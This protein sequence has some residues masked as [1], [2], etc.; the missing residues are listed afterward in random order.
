MRNGIQFVQTELLDVAYEEDGPRSGAPVILLHGWPDDVR[1]WDG[2]AARLSAAG[3][4]TVAPYLRGC[5]PGRF[6]NESTIR[7]GQLAALGSD[8]VEMAR[9]LGLGRFALVGHDWGARAAYIAT[10]ELVQHVTHLV[11][12]S[13]GYGT[14]DPRQQLQ[15]VQVR[16]YW[17]HWYFALPQGIDLVKNSRRELAR[18]L[19]AT[20]SPAW[21]FADADYAATAAS[22]DNPDWAEVTVHSYRHRWG[23]ADGDPRYDALER[24]LSCVPAIQVPTLVLHGDAD[25]CNDPVTSADKGKFFTSRYE[26]K[27]LPGIG[28]FP[29]R[30]TPDRVAD[31]VIAWLRD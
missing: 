5:G 15:L 25:A 10:T 2:V 4:H 27:L 9:A 28:H 16:N 7:S 24:R 6:L 31:E 1:T 22:F 30:E 14:N 11:T 8:V 13:V 23:Y 17:Y 12:L 3:F 29:Q 21:Q 19:W 20:W 26:R 18:F